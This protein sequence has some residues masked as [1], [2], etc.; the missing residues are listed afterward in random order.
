LA[1][2]FGQQGKFCALAAAA[3]S[4][5]ENAPRNGVVI[6]HGLEGPAEIAIRVAGGFGFHEKRVQF[7]VSEGARVT[8]IADSAQ[9][10][11]LYWLFHSHRKASPI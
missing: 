4:I 5:D 8:K 3:M 2:F 7:I 1:E 6:E 11:G 9:R 10:G